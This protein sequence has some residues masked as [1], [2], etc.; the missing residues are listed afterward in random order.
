MVKLLSTVLSLLLIFG[1][2]VPSLAQV[3]QQ[4]ET[5]RLKSQVYSVTDQVRSDQTRSTV[6]PTLRD[7]E[8][9]QSKYNPKDLVVLQKISEL[10]AEW[11]TNTNEDDGDLSFEE[12]EKEYRKHNAPLLEEAKKQA[13]TPEE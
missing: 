6:L 11:K 5:E 1:S 2:V 3:Q 7:I 9:Q 10:I 4:K 12:F 13:K 8:R